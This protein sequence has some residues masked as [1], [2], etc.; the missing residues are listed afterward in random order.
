MK[1]ELIIATQK[2]QPGKAAARRLT[3][4]L[5]ALGL[6]ALRERFAVPAR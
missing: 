5:D 4:M 6:H 2:H 3:E 1:N